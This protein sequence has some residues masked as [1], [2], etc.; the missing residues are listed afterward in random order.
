M[1]KRERIRILKA[2]L[3]KEFP[4]THCFLH[5]N[6]EYELL[7]AVLLS[8]QARDEVVN[9][10][11]PV[12]FSKYPSL[13]ELMNARYEDV[14]KIIKPVGLGPAKARNII[15]LATDLVTKFNGEVPTSR[16]DLTSL[17][18]VG[19]KTASVVRG[20]L[21]NK[22]QIPC[23]THVKRVAYRL[24]LASKTDDPSKIEAMFLKN[25]EGDDHINFHRQ[26][27]LFGRNICIAN[28]KRRCEV[29]P[30]DC[31][32]RLREYESKNDNE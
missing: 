12:L 2:F 19:E 4:E 25:F 15:S 7:I 8:A 6:K 5:H 10:V 30:L 9:S 16:E 28:N 11:T 18:G 29:C 31:R 23:D 27:I 24:K 21:F 17:S 3:D 20:E 1:T 22:K 32:E 13:E 14:L 26:M